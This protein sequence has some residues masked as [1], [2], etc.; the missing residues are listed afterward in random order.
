M[1]E[2]KAGD[3]GKRLESDGTELEQGARATELMCL[4]EGGH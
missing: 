1:G 3:W 2:N 4:L